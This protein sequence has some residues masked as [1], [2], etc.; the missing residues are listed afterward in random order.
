MGAITIRN[1]PD[2]LIDR[3]K[4]TAAAHNRSMEQEVRELLERNY[5]P[6]EEVL[7]R[8]RERWQELPETTPEETDHWRDEGRP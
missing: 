1:L 4:E 3:M 5:A 2:D 7:D 8:V 6:R